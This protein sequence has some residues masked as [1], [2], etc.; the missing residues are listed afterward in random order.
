METLGTTHTESKSFIVV[1]VKFLISGYAVNE[2][3]EIM[4]GSCC[5]VVL[6]E[7]L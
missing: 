1:A 5:S 6:T 4:S 2:T 3:S 7:L